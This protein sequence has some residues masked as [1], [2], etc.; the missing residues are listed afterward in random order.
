MS[1]SQISLSWTDRSASE[2][3]FRIE[4]S[5]LDKLHYTEIA[6]V[7]ANVTSYT[8]SGLAEATKYYYRVRAYNTIATS[9]Y[10]SEKHATTLSDI[11]APPSAL[12]ITSV[13]SNRVFLAWTDESNNEAGFKIQRKKGA[14]GT[15]EEIATLGANVTTYTDGDDALLDGTQYYYKVCAYNVAGSSSFSNAVNGTTLLATP[16]SLSATAVSSSQISLTWTDKSASEV[17]FKIE[18]SPLDKLHYTEIATVGANVTSYTNSGLAEATKYYYRVRA[19]NTIATSAFSSEKHA[20]TL[21]DIP[22]PPSALTITSVTSNRVFLAWTDESNNEA[23]FKIQRKK[24]ATGTYE[25][26]ATPGANVTTYTDDD[27]ALLDGTQYYYKVCAYNVAGSSSFSNAVNGTTLLAAPTS[28]AATAVSS[29][30]IS[31]TWTDKSTSEVGFKIEQSPL[32]K[33]H[34]TEIATVGA[35]V[36]SYMSSG[37]A[38]RTKYYYRVRAYNA[39]ATSAY[40]GEKNATT[41]SSIPAAPSVLTITSLTSGKVFLAWSDNSDN[42]A[43]FRI[44]RK[45]GATGTYAE[46]ATPGANVTTYTDNDDALLDGTQYYYKICAYNAAGDSPFSNTVNGTTLLATPTSLS[47]T[48]VSSSQ[49]SL[50]W[51]D[52]SASE[53]GYLIERK[54]TMTGT[55]G[56]I[57]SVDMNVHSYTDTYIFSSHTRY[58]YRVRATNGTINSGY[59]NESFATP[60]P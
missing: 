4:Q 45:K 26:I 28:L 57:G 48:A 37:L 40:S 46:I 60:A 43:G 53:T 5:P 30:E 38:E 56:Q 3:G 42:E 41:L 20:T 27:D 16:T 11:P 1:S 33:L 14:T 55:Y 19:Y 58:Y 15:Y 9:A 52:K 49:V 59:S 35:N 10:S 7:G 54:E 22:A 50:T 31:L 32:D 17:G 39:I 6:T 47:A 36:T 12:T 21:S 34:Y 18:Q 13:T 24:G 44:Q 8:N 23:G 29:S 2:A 51:T 25:E